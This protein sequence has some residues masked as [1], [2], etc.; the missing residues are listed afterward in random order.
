V[1]F[2]DLQKLIES[3]PNPEQ[4]KAIQR[5]RDKAFCHWDRGEHKEK[6][7]SSNGDCCF[8][9]IIG[10]PKKNGKRMTLFDYEGMSYRALVKP[11]YFNSYP[12]T[13]S[14]DIPSGNVLYPFRE[15]FVDT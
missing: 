3:Q 4:T 2:K 8:N 14:K 15:T 9:H 5:L 11:G 13:K 7:R 1:T 6:D 10:L 12:A